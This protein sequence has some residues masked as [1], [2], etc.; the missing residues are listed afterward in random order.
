MDIDDLRNP[1][2][3]FLQDAS[4][5][6]RKP[7]EVR[8]AW[9]KQLD[10]Q[11]RENPTLRLAAEPIRRQMVAKTRAMVFLCGSEGTPA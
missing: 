9:L 5:V 8:E 7:V 1:V 11:A 10:Q 4:V 2:E 6:L 3:E